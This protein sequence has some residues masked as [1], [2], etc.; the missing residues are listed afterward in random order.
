[1]AKIDLKRMAALGKALGAELWLEFVIPS[2]DNFEQDLQELGRELTSW[3]ILL[4]LS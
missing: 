4:Q 1:M 3:A 2:V